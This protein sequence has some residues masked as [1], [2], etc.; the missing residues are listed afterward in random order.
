ME[1]KGKRREKVIHIGIKGNIRKS[2]NIEIKGISIE[3]TC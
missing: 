3:S 2:I 1:I